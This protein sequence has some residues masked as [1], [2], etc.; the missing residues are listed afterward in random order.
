MSAIGYPPQIIFGKMHFPL[1]PENE[2]THEIKRDGITSFEDFTN[3]SCLPH[4]VAHYLT[5]LRQT[6]S[7]KQ[8]RQSRT[9]RAKWSKADLTEQSRAQIFC[10]TFPP[11]HFPRGCPPPL[12]PHGY[13][14][15][16]VR[17]FAQTITVVR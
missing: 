17:D 13:A 14:R 16:G 12:P 7:A 2:F 10:K 11:S 3:T 8:N 1:I 4:K 6:G 5:L 15:N 9:G